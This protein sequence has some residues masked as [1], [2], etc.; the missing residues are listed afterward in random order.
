MKK[1]PDIHKQ[2][3]PNFRT[4][5]VVFLLFGVACREKVGLNVGNS[6]YISQRQFLCT[7]SVHSGNK[8]SQIGSKQ[9][10]RY[11]HQNNTKKFTE[12]I[13]TALTQ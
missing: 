12:D 13:G 9:F 5:I 3:C 8:S 11:R 7:R 6:P 1:E 4:N 10:H 2:T